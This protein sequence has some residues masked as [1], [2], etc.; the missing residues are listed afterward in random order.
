[1]ERQN[2][3]A[4]LNQS[5]FEDLLE[6]FTNDGWAKGNITR[7]IKKF[8]SLCKIEYNDSLRRKGS[9]IFKE[10]LE[11]QET[12]VVPTVN[13]NA[14][15]LL[16]D[17]ETSFIET[18]TFSLYPNYIPIKNITK[19]WFILS[20]SYK[21]LMEDEVKSFYL[22]P[23]EALAGNDERIVKELWKLFDEADVLVAHNLQK[24]DNKK[25]NARFLKYDLKLPSPYKQIDT[26]LQ[27][28][29]MFA[30]TSNK[31]DYLATFLGLEGKIENTEALWHRVM[32]GDAEAMKEMV[33][34][35]EQ[36]VHLLEEVYLKLRPYFRG[37]Q[38]FGI[39]VGDDI[40]TCP[41]CASE[42]LD[43]NLQTDYVTQVNRYKAFRCNCCGSLGRSRTP[44]K[45]ANKQ[46]TLPLAGL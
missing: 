2:L 1:M 30:L 23:E 42:D 40:A 41:T 37:A 35:N 45:T 8:C 29:K 5:H 11:R 21:Y 39:Y 25:A 43:W 3:D 28:R 13:H 10:G 20:F 22:T 46:L 9:N 6:I 44:L 38:N 33:L 26:L 14:K 18:R 7:T 34:Y 27:A 16:F 36:D 4:V 24:F 17:L 15:I 31:L 12:K 19:D 32:N